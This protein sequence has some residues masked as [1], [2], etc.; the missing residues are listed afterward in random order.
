[1]GQISLVPCRPAQVGLSRKGATT[2]PAMPP[3]KRWNPRAFGAAG[4]TR[5][6]FASKPS[7]DHPLHWCSVTGGGPMII[8]CCSGPSPFRPPRQLTMGRDT[9]AEGVS[10]AVSLPCPRVFRAPGKEPPNT[11][12]RLPSNKRR[13]QSETGGGAWQRSILAATRPRNADRSAPVSRPDH[14]LSNH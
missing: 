7:G 1:M 12:M 9:R 11:R 8:C 2:L 4:K 13:G 3:A 5:Q 10:G 14:Q 6:L